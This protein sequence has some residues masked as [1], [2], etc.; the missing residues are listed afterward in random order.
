[1]MPA[2][3]LRPASIGRP[4][5]HATVYAIALCAKKLPSPSLSF[6]LLPEGCSLLPCSPAPLLPCSPA[7][8]LPCSPARLLPCSPAPFPSPCSLGRRRAHTEVTLT[9]SPHFQ[10][11]TSSAR[12]KPPLL[13]PWQAMDARARTRRLN[14]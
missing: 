7:P 13:F 1:M 8:L 2:P 4:W 10:R 3:T 5:A 9:P 14:V 12:C 11:H 6:S